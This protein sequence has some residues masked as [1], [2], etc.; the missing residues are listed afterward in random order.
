[1][2]QF[3]LFYGDMVGNGVSTSTSLSA[4]L[5]PAMWV[6]RVQINSQLCLFFTHKC[7]KWPIGLKK[8]AEISMAEIGNIK[9]NRKC[10][11]VILHCA[12]RL[13]KV[14]EPAH[15]NGPAT[16]IKCL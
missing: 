13:P 7:N 10:P 1:M 6:V 3:S 14:I 15:L 2:Q 12:T 11:N 5:M 8:N 4:R 16:S 9:F